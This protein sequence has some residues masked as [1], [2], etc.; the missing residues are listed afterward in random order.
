MTPQESHTRGGGVVALRTALDS[1]F[2]DLAHLG[3]FVEG[4]VDGGAADLGKNVGRP[5]MHFVSTQMHVDS[6]KRLSDGAALCGE[7]I[8]VEAKSVQKR[9]VHRQ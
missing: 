2:Q 9:S 6:I 5:S 7:A 1:Q 8:A 4:A 3:E